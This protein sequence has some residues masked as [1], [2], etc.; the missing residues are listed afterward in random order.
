[1]RLAWLTDIHL[2]FLDPSA[3]AAFAERVAATDTTDVVITGDIAEADDLEASLE[4]LAAVVARPVWFVLGNHDFYGASIRDVRARMRALTARDL[5]LRWL[6]AVGLVQI[7][8]DVALV[9]HDGWGDA[10]FGDFTAS[11]VVLHDFTRIRDLSGLRDGA[12]RRRLETLG[13]QAAACLRDDLASLP[14]WVRTV[15]V[16]THVPPFREACWHEGAIS[17]DHWLPFFACRAT[18]EV[19]REAATTHVGTRFLVLCGHT[20]GG[21]E[22][23]I[24]PNLHVATGAAEYGAPVIRVIDPT[25]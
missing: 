13:D 9:G 14:T 5:L 25:L 18:G 4:E 23:D 22:V 7:S 17:D 19:L 1:V 24:L 2:N 15:I 16:A 20:H 3:R 11:P 10:R 6:P 12:L 21:G 8:D